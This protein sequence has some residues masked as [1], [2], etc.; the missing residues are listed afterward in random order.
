[1]KKRGYAGGKKNVKRICSHIFTFFPTEYP[2]FQLS[3]LFKYLGFLKLV[4]S[5]EFL[6]S[7]KL[8]DEY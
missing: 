5:L 7:I 6:K 4:W 8:I 2:S 1:M 3:L